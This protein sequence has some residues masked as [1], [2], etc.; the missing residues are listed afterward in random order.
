[1]P[2]LHDVTARLQP[3]CGTVFHREGILRKKSKGEDAGVAQ[4]TDTSATIVTTISEKRDQVC[5]SKEI[6]VEAASRSSA[7]QRRCRG[8]SGRCSP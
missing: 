5:H 3:S 2:R 1:M 8:T 4:R 7:A 6:T